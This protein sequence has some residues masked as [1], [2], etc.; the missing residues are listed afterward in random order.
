MGEVKWGILGN[1]TIGRKCVMPAITKS[2]NGRIVA[3]ASRNPANAARL[4]EEHDIPNLYG[5]YHQV[6]ENPDV[7]AV[8]IPLPNSLHL[9]WVVKALKSGKHV[10]CEKPL[11]CN[12][13]EAREMADCA[14]ENSR[15]LMEALMYRFHPRTIRLKTMVAEGAI[16][17]PRLIRG[18]FCFSMDEKLLASGDNYRLHPQFG[19]GALLDV[20]CY[21]VSICRWIFDEE[22]STVEVQAIYHES[23]DVDIHLVGSMRFNS[24]KLATIEASFCSGL[25]QTYTVVGSAGALELPHDAFI[26]WEKD[27]VIEWRKRDDDTG[28]CIVVAGADEYQLMVEHFGDVLLKGE[29]LQ[30][31]PEESIANL[32]VLDTLAIAA[33]KNR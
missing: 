15:V 29:A 28:E 3:L 21:L 26:P 32:E 19:G 16:G 33:R 5:D 31:P 4:A 12:A 10:L 9:P 17:I 11:A 1:S 13:A 20:G 23:F 7:T 22:P 25:Q 14:V 6:L 24:G 18:A 8:Y 27:A 30:I 2:S